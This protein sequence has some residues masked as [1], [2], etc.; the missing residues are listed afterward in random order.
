MVSFAIKV[1][2]NAV[3]LWVAAWLIP[4]IS[5]GG[6]QFG[7]TFATV[8]LVALLFGVLNAILKPIVKFFSFPLIVLTLGLFTFVVNAFMLQVTEWISDPLGLNFTID[9]FWWD[10]ILGALVI[11]IVA[12]ILN[13]VLPDR[14][15][16]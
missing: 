16:D 8:L 9:H 3:A 5:F 7:S 15:D 4:G 12:M 1:L 6:G 14:D 2:V 10:A 13:W 11:T